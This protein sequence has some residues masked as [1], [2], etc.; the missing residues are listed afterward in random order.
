[1][2]IYVHMKLFDTVASSISAVDHH[3]TQ[4]KHAPAFLQAAGVSVC[5]NEWNHSF[6]LLPPSIL[7]R[8]S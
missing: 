8:H 3:L 5:R 7:P 4:T 1:M 2:N 6:P